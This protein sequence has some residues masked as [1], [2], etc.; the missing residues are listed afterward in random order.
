LLPPT[1][2]CGGSL[3]HLAFAAKGFSDKLL[4][5]GFA[6]ILGRKIYLMNDIPQDEIYYEEIVAMKP[7][8]IHGDFTLL[9]WPAKQLKFLP[10]MDRNSS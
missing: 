2:V 7:V 10:E 5:I 1:N 9:T 8:I 3:L 4:E 6:Y